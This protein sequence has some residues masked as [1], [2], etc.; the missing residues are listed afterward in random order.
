[1]REVQRRHTRP[2][3]SEMTQE[4]AQR[5]TERT[6]EAL[7][8]AGCMRLPPTSVCE[9]RGCKSRQRTVYL[10]TFKLKHPIRSGDPTGDDTI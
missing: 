9:C 3:E 1:M 10:S 7:R 4:A 5:T 2:T 6:G 8:A